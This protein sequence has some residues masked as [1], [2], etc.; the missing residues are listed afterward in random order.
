MG[1]TPVLQWH[2][3]VLTFTISGQTR[4]DDIESLISTN[5]E[6]FQLILDD[7]SIEWNNSNNVGRFGDKATETLQK[8]GFFA[9]SNPEGLQSYSDI[10][11]MIDSEYFPDWIQDH[12]YPN[13]GQS[14][15]EFAEQLHSHDG[16]NN[17]YF[18]DD[19]NSADS[20]LSSLCGI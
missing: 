15:H 17:Y 16:D 10:S 2:N 3:I 12:L 14:P 18:S 9:D 4:S 20:I 11:C 5:K 13:K 19:M 6:N 1:S 7:S 8:L